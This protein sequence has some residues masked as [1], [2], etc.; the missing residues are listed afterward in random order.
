MQKVIHCG[1]F[2]DN[3]I[4]VMAQPITALG[5]VQTFSSWEGSKDTNTHENIL[6]IIFNL[7]STDSDEENISRIKQF[8]PL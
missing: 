3:T 2:H 1:I 5:L 7:C 8:P 4:F 6:L